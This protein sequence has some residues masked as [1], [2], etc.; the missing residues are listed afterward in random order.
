MVIQEELKGASERI[1]QQIQEL[2]KEA[3]EKYQISEEK[4]DESF[5]LLNQLFILVNGQM[6]EKLGNM[7]VVTF[8][9]MIEE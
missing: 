4:A 9:S 3:P 8:E 5:S 2:A 6:M 7:D 1:D